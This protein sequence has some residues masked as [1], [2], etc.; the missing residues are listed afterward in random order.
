[1]KVVTLRQITAETSVA[2][3]IAQIDIYCKPNKNDKLP[4]TFMGKK[5]LLKKKNTLKE[6]HT[7]KSHLYEC[8]RLHATTQHIQQIPTNDE[9][10]FEKFCRT[11]LNCFR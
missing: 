5:K 1:M 7:R 2:P 6:I 10:I 8:I 9:R 3:Q 11:L 4:T